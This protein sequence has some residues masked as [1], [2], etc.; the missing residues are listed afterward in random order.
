ML[1]IR[2]VQSTVEKSN[3][4]D[5]F[6][7]TMVSLM[8]VLSSFIGSMIMSINVYTVSS[9]LKKDFSK[10]SIFSAVQVINVEQRLF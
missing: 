7:V 9:K 6:E 3:N 10:W 2:S 8:F 4:V 5:G 1:N